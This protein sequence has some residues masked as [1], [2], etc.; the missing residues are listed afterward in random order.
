MSYRLFNLRLASLAVIIGWTCAGGV[1]VSSG[2]GFRRA[3]AGVVAGV[4]ICSHGGRGGSVMVVMISIVGSF[5]VVV[6]IV[7]GAAVVVVCCGC[8]CCCR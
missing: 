1:V 5:M 2:V 4:S 8:C 3:G 7:V 6:S